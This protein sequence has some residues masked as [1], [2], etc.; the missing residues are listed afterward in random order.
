M[1]VRDGARSDSVS[2]ASRDA[3]A[4]R[5]RQPLYPP[6]GERCVS[7][8]VSPAMQSAIVLTM[9]SGTGGRATIV[10]NDVT[11]NGFTEDI[12]ELFD[13]TISPAGSKVR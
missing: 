9:A 12:S 4:A 3:A 1:N 10:P 8:N 2:R 6:A 7:V 11:A 5:R 13:R